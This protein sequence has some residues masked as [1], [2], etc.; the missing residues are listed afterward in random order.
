MQRGK[1]SKKYIIYVVLQAYVTGVAADHEPARLDIDLERLYLNVQQRCDDDDDAPRQD[2]P[3]LGA[4]PP[5]HDRR[6]VRVVRSASQADSDNSEVRMI[7][8]TMTEIKLCLNCAL[9]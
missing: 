8:T 3:Y 1:K 9:I 6:Q 4:E 2:L 5:Q 7:A